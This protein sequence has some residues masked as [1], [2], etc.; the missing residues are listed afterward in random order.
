MEPLTAITMIA[1]KYGVSGVIGALTGN[2]ELG[3]VSAELVG[4]LAASEDRLGEKL[5]AIEGRLDEVLEQR[6]SAAIGAG[7]RTLLD[8]G[9][10][11]D[12]RVRADELVR[13]RDLFRDAGASARTPLQVAVAERYL[14]LCAVALGRR[15]TARVAW[16]LLNK[17]A[18]EALIGAMPVVG[19]AAYERAREQLGRS[20]R[21]VFRARREERIDELAD[22]ILDAASEVVELALDLLAEAADLTE[23]VGAVRALE[24][25]SDFLEPEEDDDDRL[26]TAGRLELR[27]AGPG[28]IR[29]GPLS[30][31]WNSVVVRPA[32]ALDVTV[33]VRADPVLSVPLQL[34]LSATAAPVRPARWA[35]PYHGFLHPGAPEV[36]LTQSLPTGGPSG[37]TLSVNDVLLFRSA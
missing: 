33:T 22:E 34:A 16:G 2:Q 17:S 36:R 30:V 29:I 7:L 21:P 1:A 23:A 11:R 31:W 24:P 5:S 10:T 6:Y 28:P 19:P 13:A 27:P 35:L 14:V 37:C 25:G 20:G 4:A 12:P 32:G 18:F 26:R 15:E 3:S 8:A 9:T